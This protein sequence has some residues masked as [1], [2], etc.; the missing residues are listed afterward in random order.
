MECESGVEG[1]FVA[2]GA[3]VTRATMAG[4]LPSWGP[5]TWI[6]AAQM[7]RTAERRPGG[8]VSPVWCPP[9]RTLPSSS[10]SASMTFS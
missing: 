6:A 7:A 5:R 10:I 8:A 3:V 2:S 4:S 9:A 1:E